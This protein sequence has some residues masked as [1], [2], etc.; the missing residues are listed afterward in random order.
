M[1][2]DADCFVCVFTCTFHFKEA[3]AGNGKRRL[4]GWLKSEEREEGHLRHIYE[5]KVKIKGLRN[6]NTILS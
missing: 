4:L 3:E 1:L 6:S 5:F 2:L